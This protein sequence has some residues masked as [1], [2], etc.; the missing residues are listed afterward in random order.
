MARERKLTI[1]VLGD[2]KAAAAQMGLLEKATGSLN[3]ILGQFGINA[4][5]ALG[6]AAAMGVAALANLGAAFDDVEDT[7]R[8]QTGATGAD[9][10]GLMDDF[11]AVATET[12]ATFEQV[13]AAIAGLN[14][15]TGAT[16]ETLQGLAQQVL[17]LSRLTGSDLN[18]NIEAS[19]QLFNNWNVETGD[20]AG[21]LDK[22]FRAAQTSGVEV[23]NLMGNVTQ[24]GPVLR[25]M[26]I[27]LDESIAMFAKWEEEGVDAGAMMAGMRRALAAFAD[28]GRPAAQALQETI[29]AI[30]GAG[31]ESEAAAIAVEIFGS[32]AGPA[33][34]ANI[35]EGRF[36][37]EDYLDTISNGSD[38]ILGVAEETK[39]WQERLQELK[40][41]IAV[42]LEPVANRVFEGIG[43]LLETLGPIIATVAVA[44]G[45]VLGAAFQI[46]GAAVEAIMPI[47]EALM[48]VLSFLGDAASALAGFISG[49]LGTLDMTA[50]VWGA[51]NGALEEG[52][53]RIEVLNGLVSYLT[54][55]GE[56]NQEAVAR[57]KEEY[58]YTNEEIAAA[59]QNVEGMTEAT[60]TNT[61]S[62]GFAEE[63]Y[64]L[65][66]DTVVDLT[67]KIVQLATDLRDQE[68][69]TREVQQAE[70][71]LANE[72]RDA[73]NPL[74]QYQ[75]AQEELTRAHE[76]AE[77]Q[78][79]ENGR[80]S[81]E[82]QAALLELVIAQGNAEAAE[83]QLRME[84]GPAAAALRDLGAKAGITEADLRGLESQFRLTGA[85]GAQLGTSIRQGAIAGLDG[86]AQQLANKI[87][88]A[89][90]AAVAQVSAALGIGSPSKV[91]AQKLGRP[92]GEGV[93]AGFEDTKTE[94]AESF[95]DLPIPTYTAEPGSIRRR[96]LAGEVGAGAPPTSM[97]VVV[98]LDGRTIARAIIE[99]LV[100]LIRLRTGTKL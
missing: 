44:V 26:G 28:Q 61:E 22:L 41:T 29:N 53:D 89:V 24:F 55:Q 47:L 73:L 51:F 11:R 80:S 38:T 72:R 34:A 54:T 87:A 70:L 100:E 88:G 4:G 50:E 45:E 99:P 64:G 68:S 16:G 92:I 19:T 95:Q 77:T 23:G 56:L 8:T 57:L 1:T 65:A 66:A 97:T 30:K 25:Q 69:A 32:R 13:G 91:V 63:M 10:D 42:Q 48:P 81:D 58:G 96:R 83:V 86:L 93:I 85:Q 76:E 60:E 59:I 79:R 2:T 27:G 21:T 3:G 74:A 7:I 40:N 33:M 17:E 78:L 82:Y 43:S 15:R 98:E 14:Q 12:P 36:E 62:M 46:L 37:I 5:M 84:A 18:G 49:L 9:L 39:D 71:D 52:A 20:Q 90:Q 67:G 6:A 35:R 94:M 75:R 31:T